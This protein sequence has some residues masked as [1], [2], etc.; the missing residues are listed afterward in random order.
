MIT[1]QKTDNIQQH[2]KIA[3]VTSL[4]LALVVA[5][6]LM[7]YGKQDSFVLINGY[8]HPSLDLFFQYITFLGDGLIY[9]PI[10]LY[11]A[12]YNRKYLVAVIAGIIICT[13][14]TQFLKN[15]VFSN[16]LRPI[17][18]EAKKIIIH[19]ID[20]LTIHREHSFPS[21]HTSTAFSMALLLAAIMK[22][23]FW[24]IILPLIAFMVGYSRVYLSQHFVTDVFAG[25]T[26]GIVTA[27]LSL[28]IYFNY[29]KRREQKKKQLTS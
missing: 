14:L 18:L 20:G 5:I 26:I 23:K 17:S 28:L 15:V 6:F 22:R 8:Y 7:I 2:F 27:Y 11:C 29:L 16:E 1:E 12:V 21:G 24:C 4:V 13:I 25:M 9:I 10:A 3:V 19:K